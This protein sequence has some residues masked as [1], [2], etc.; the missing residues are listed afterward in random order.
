MIT[1]KDEFRSVCPAFFRERS[2]APKI[3]FKILFDKLP[4]VGGRH[5][6]I[7]SEDGLLDIKQPRPM[8]LGK[9]DAT[10]PAHRDLLAEFPTWADAYKRLVNEAVGCSHGHFQR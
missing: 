8:N 5:G 1:D 3:T 2:H 6:Q 9:G 7:R 4:T 10:N